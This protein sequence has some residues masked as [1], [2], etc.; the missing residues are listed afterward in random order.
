MQFIPSS[1]SL[2]YGQKLYF[3]SAFTRLRTE[4]GDTVAIATGTW[5]FTISDTS[6]VSAHSLS[7]HA[8]FLARKAGTATVKME[9]PGTSAVDTVTV[10][11]IQW[12]AGAAGCGLTTTGRAYCWGPGN[13]RLGDWRTD[14]TIFTSSGFGFT[15]RPIAVNSN[16]TFG[17]ITRNAFLVCAINQVARA[18]CWG[19]WNNRQGFKQFPAPVSNAL[20]FKQIRIGIAGSVC[21]ITTDDRAFCWGNNAAG[22]LG[23]ASTDKCLA[24][25]PT[26]GS[27]ELD[28]SLAPIEVSGGKRWR[29]VNPGLWHTCGVTTDN[30]TFCWGTAPDANIN[31]LGIE[32]D[33]IIETCVSSA[34][35]ISFPCTRVPLRVNAPVQFTELSTHGN[36]T[37]ALTTSGDV[38]CW[39]SHAASS[40]AVSTTP[41]RVNA[42]LGFRSLIGD[43]N[44][45]CGL[46]AAGAVH[47]WGRN[48]GGELGL[49]SVGGEVKTPTR[50]NVGATI[51][52]LHF[53]G[54]VCGFG[55]D[56]E[57]YCW[58]A[59]GAIAPEVPLATDLLQPRPRGTPTRIPTQ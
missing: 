2:L 6:I 32:R 28:C 10:Q 29:T 40:A 19:D 11:P 5:T 1:V 17:F 38:Y 56:K 42:G 48:H 34:Q 50:V 20:S 58:G 51:T 35:G 59:T 46:D 15:S 55:T 27:I 33:R 57:T 49:G 21:G 31:A 7:S 36:S 3:D 13:G 54:S 39:G 4:L 45:L 37:C 52:S 8:F 12:S 41:G 16:Q 14:E 53:G 9:R 43:D 24:E 30:E 18:Y 25:T 22:Q 47:C 23:A 26:G 44:F